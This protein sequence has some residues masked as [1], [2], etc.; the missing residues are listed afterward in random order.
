MGIH[1]KSNGSLT[2][3]Q[4]IH[5]DKLN[6]SHPKFKQY[7]VDRL[8]ELKADNLPKTVRN[9]NMKRDSIVAQTPVLVIGDGHS[10]KENLNEIKKFSG[11]VLCLDVNFNNLVKNGII[12][13]YVVTL[14]SSI[15]IIDESVFN[16]S[17]LKACKDKTIAIGSAITTNEIIKHITVCGVP[18]QRWDFDEEPRTSN[19]GMFAINFAKLYLKAD[20]ILL[21]GFEHV[22][23][24][25]PN[26]TYLTWQV[27]FW[28][29]I[30]KW[31]KET[32]VNCTN[33]GVLYYKDYIVDTSL[34]K[35]QIKND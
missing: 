32:I 3:S 26:Q 13:D 17:C 22:G 34:D 7:V 15:I 9:K 28:H 23:S 4:K 8:D 16:S 33:G 12:P 1:L 30:Q 24:K 31:P 2:E 14:E 27:D 19:V 25:Y 20:K 6:I 29:F 10:Y 5:A 11:K 35:L 21:V 18:F